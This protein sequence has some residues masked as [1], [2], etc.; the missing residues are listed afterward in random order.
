MQQKIGVLG[1]GKYSTDFYIDQLHKKYHNLKGGFSTFPYLLYQVDFNLLNPYLPNQFDKLIP[2]LQEIVLEI[3]KLPIQKWII[4]NITLHETFD[5]LETKIDIIH[6]AAIIT[7]YCTSRSTKSLV[8]FGTKYTMESGYL[9]SA[10]AKNN[11]EIHQPEKKDLFWIDKLRTKI[12]QLKN[13][14][15]D[16]VNF[17]KL[18]E[19]YSINTHVLIACT[20]LSIISEEINSN[21]VVDIAGLQID[22]A[23][24]FQLKN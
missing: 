8:N 5:Q 9:K 4:P 6:P 11:I 2:T 15:E 23:I 24:G 16:L 10:L 3:E 18:V 7:K 20:E 21:K 1:L 12:Y 13:T 22:E 19:K 14:S 17:K